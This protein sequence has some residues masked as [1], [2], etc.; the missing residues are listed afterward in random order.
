METLQVGTNPIRAKVKVIHKFQTDLRWTSSSTKWIKGDKIEE[1]DTSLA[2]ILQLWIKVLCRDSLNRSHNLARSRAP[3][4]VLASIRLGKLRG[5]SKLILRRRDQ[6]LPSWTTWCRKNLELLPIQDL[7]LLQTLKRII[8]NHSLQNL[9]W[10][11]RNC[12]KSADNKFGHP[13]LLKTKT[14]SRCHFKNLWHHRKEWWMLP[15]LLYQK[16]WNNRRQIRWIIWTK[17]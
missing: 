12:D 9:W 17:Y 10:F 15:N 3:D 8:S 14:S 2:E 1:A 16:L 5:V 7:I 11:S 6:T 4:L 13:K